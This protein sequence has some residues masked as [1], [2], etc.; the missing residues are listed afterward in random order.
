MLDLGK[1]AVSGLAGGVACVVAGH[2]LDSTKVAMQTSASQVGAPAIFLNLL[3]QR[4]L[5]AGAIPALAANAAENA[6]LFVCYGEV[7]R[8]AQHV[9]GEHLS[10][11]LFNAA[12]GSVAGGVTAF[13]LCPIE[14]VKCQMQ[15]HGSSAGIAACKAGM[16]R[17]GLPWLFR[18]LSWT[19]AREV[20]PGRGS[21]PC[22]TNPNLTPHRLREVEPPAHD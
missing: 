18:G 12:C 2:P 11:M 4:R 17:V 21:N 14:L 15:V 20:D 16:R 7:H 19:L 5:Y 13:I 9:T 22:T 1:D 10:P 8:L 6:T 3:R